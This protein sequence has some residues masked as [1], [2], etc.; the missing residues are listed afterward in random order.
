MSN[1]EPLEMLARIV[2]AKITPDFRELRISLELTAWLL[3][4]IPIQT[5]V[6][7][8]ESNALERMKTHLATLGRAT[9]IPP[10]MAEQLIGRHV[11]VALN[12]RLGVEGYRRFL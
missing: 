7:G 10:L 9:G 12:E 11:I 8:D 4:R 1:D 5:P 6:T 2:D 3:D